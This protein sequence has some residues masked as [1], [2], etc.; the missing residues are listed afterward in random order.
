MLVVAD[1]SPIIVLVLIG[2]VGVLP[3]LFGQVVIPPEV[4]A[5]LLH[6][7]RPQTVRDFMTDPPAWLLERR[8]L[9]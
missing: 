8:R 5:E 4:S 7:K 9:P 1:S 6:P 3:K 2:H